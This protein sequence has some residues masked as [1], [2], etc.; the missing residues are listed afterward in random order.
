MQAL[1]S[2]KVVGLESW[3]WTLLDSSL[4]SGS[5]DLDLDLNPEDL[6]LELELEDFNELSGV[7]PNLFGELEAKNFARELT[8]WGLGHSIGKFEIWYN[9]RPQNSL[10]KCLIMWKS[11]Q[12]L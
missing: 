8:Q 7:N 12:G 11:Y 2:A 6:G 5:L 1:S 4:C 10:P 9:L 3:T